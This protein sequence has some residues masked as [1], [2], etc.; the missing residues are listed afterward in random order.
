MEI[1]EWWKSKFPHTYVK[2]S[3][4]RR[5]WEVML[6]IRLDA[7]IRMD[8]EYPEDVI[9]DADELFRR[10]SVDAIGEFKEFCQPTMDYFGWGYLRWSNKPVYK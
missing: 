4:K 10:V 6:Y 8:F 7:P 2:F 5:A 9:T 1:P 3:E